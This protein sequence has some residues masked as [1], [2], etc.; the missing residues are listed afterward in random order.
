M[1]YCI[2][3]MYAADY[4]KESFGRLGVTY[5]PAAMNKSDFLLEFAGLLATGQLRL[6]DRPELVR[7][8]AS[9]ERKRGSTRDRVDHPRGAHDDEAVSCALAMI[10]AA[11]AARDQFGMCRSRWLQA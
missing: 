3:D 9:L 6:I 7:E 4:V 2:G 1:S 10:T 5:Q 8:L 11:R